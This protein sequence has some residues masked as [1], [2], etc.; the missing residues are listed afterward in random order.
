MNTQ[1]D[2]DSIITLTDIINHFKNYKPYGN[3]DRPKIYGFIRNYTQFINV[4]ENINS[5][6]G[7]DD[8]KISLVN[9]IKSFVVHYTLYGTPSNREKLHTLIYG[10]PGTGKTHMGRLLA[11]F[12]TVSGCLKPKKEEPPSLFSGGKIPP[13]LFF[14]A[15]DF[16]SDNSKNAQV[17]LINQIRKKCNSVITNEND[18]KYVGNKLQKLKTL[19]RKDGDSKSESKSDKSESNTLAS[20]LS[21]PP[22]SNKLITHDE[23]TNESIL[24]PK[25]FNNMDIDKDEKVPVNFAVLTRGDLIGQYAG[26]TTDRVRKIFDKYDG[27][28]LL[29]DE[30]Y[31]LC[32]SEDDKFGREIITE[33][34]SYMTNYPDR[35]VFIFAGYKDQ[36]NNT[37]MKIQPGLARRFNWKIDVVPPSHD[38]MFEILK[39]QLANHKLTLSSDINEHVLN[40]IE[41]NILYFPNY[42]GDTERLSDMIKDI[43]ESELW[44][45]VH[46]ENLTKDELLVHAKTVN[47]KTFDKAYDFYIKNS[48]VVIEI[49]NPLHCHMYS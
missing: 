12:W 46:N 41:K 19:L 4:L 42:G 15:N 3:L 30:V 31:E 49:K 11:E 8:F 21:L 34:I 39:L 40:T 1:Y 45:N 44:N 5:L 20:F 7:F 48:N 24:T 14:I 36:I 9:K 27:G 33:I 47:L 17:T 28:A 23:D 26:H 16:V 37:I 6:I 18:K 43:Q 25:E 29:L 10:P 22:K 35:I 38:K 13:L 2:P 32:S